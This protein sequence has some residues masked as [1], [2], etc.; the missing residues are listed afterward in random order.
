M[1]CLSFIIIVVADPLGLSSGRRLGLL[2]CK[3]SS[4]LDHYIV[5]KDV[6]QNFCRDTPWRVTAL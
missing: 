1:L 3:K 6:E 4:K 2:N 5:L